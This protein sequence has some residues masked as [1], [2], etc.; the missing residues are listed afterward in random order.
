MLSALWWVLYEGRNFYSKT[1]LKGKISFGLYSV[2]KQ[3]A[4]NSLIVHKTLIFELGQDFWVES[5]WLES[6]EFVHMMFGSV[7]LKT[8]LVEVKSHLWAELWILL[9]F[10][11]NH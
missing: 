4:E 8:A 9:L 10:L 7:S 6:I 11:N 5:D 2:Q 1:D 3:N